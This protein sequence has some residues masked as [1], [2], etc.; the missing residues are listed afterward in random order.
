MRSNIIL[1]LPVAASAAQIHAA[2]TDVS[3]GPNRAPSPIDETRESRRLRME[4]LARTAQQREAVRRLQQ[5]LDFCGGEGL[6]VEGDADVKIHQEAL[7]C[8]LS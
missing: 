8:F 7:K 6:A 3:P 2:L 5:R 4:A 1:G